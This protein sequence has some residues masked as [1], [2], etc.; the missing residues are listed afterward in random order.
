MIRPIC[1]WL[2]CASGM[3]LAGRGTCAWGNPD[4]PNCPEFEKYLEFEEV[5]DGETSEEAD[6]GA[7]KETISN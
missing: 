5:T 4:D 7:E 6:T 1:N 3:G 2:E